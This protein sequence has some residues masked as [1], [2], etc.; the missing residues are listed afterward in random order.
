MKGATGAVKSILSE[1]YLGRRIPREV[2]MERVRRVI[3][4][5][6]TQTQQEIL[7]AYYF[8]GKNLTQIARERG[9]H[10]STACRTLHRA[11][12]RLKRFLRY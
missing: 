9:I 4:E 5:E 7:T 2:Q 12:D 3:R 10:K 1:G 8:G 11:E 6:L